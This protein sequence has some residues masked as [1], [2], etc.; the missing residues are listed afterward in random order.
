MFTS[1][2]FENLKSLPVKA[3]CADENI[4]EYVFQF[5]DL[6]SKQGFSVIEKKI[7]DEF[8]KVK[9]LLNI[10]GYDILIGFLMGRG[11]CRLSIIYKFRKKYHV[12]YVYSRDK[13][14]IDVINKVKEVAKLMIDQILNIEEYNEE[15]FYCHEKVD[16]EYD[17]ETNEL[18]LR[19]SLPITKEDIKELKS[20]LEEIFIGEQ[21]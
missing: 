21:R 11:T 7:S 17:E 16:A 14:L 1:Q 9:T 19:I 5:I 12:E 4:D 3:L 15:L 13:P 8:V 2:T 20:C 18:I 10:D 6:L